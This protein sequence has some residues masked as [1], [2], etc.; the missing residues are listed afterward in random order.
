VLR[1]AAIGCGLGE[2]DDHL[3]VNVCDHPKRTDSRRRSVGRSAAQHEPHVDLVAIRA[4][5]N[6]RLSGMTP[7]SSVNDD[8]IG[9]MLDSRPS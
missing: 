8:T 4:V 3:L 6:R 5:G 7:T 9:G 2:V 1:S